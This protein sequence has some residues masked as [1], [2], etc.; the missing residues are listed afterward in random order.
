M[1]A[2]DPKRTFSQ[3]LDRDRRSVGEVDAWYAAVGGEQNRRMPC[4]GAFAN[5][6][7]GKY[8]RRCVSVDRMR[9]C[10]SA[11]G[12]KNEPPAIRVARS[13]HVHIRRGTR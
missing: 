2:F 9:E 12:R 10:W 1:S 13:H 8:R 4:N 6:Y 7:V 3:E 11:T 5:R